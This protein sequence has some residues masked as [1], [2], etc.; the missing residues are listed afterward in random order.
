M[1]NFLSRFFLVGCISLFSFSCF[2]EDDDDGGNGNCDPNRVVELAN[3]YQSAAM[4]YTQNQTYANC[5]NVKQ[6]LTDFY[7]YVKNC[8][9]AGYDADDLLD[10]LDNID[11]T[12]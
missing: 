10:A 12:P 9:N 6:K 2:G 8:P 4:A 3:A 11:C 7:N 5:L 1:K